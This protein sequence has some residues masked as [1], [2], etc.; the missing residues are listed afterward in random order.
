MPFIFPPGVGCPWRE[1][2][3]IKEG[4]LFM[5]HMRKGIALLLATLM[6]VPNIP[7]F[8]ENVQSETQTEDVEDVTETTEKEVQNVE[9][10]QLQEEIESADDASVF[11]NTGNYEVGIMEDDFAEDGSYTINI[12]EENPFFP[13]EVQFTC[14]GE[15]TDEWFMTPD[16]TVEIGGHTFKVS[17]YF[18]NT[19]VTQM[20][21]NVAGNTVAVYPEK[22]EFTNDGDGTMEMSLLP[23]TQRN[24]TVDLTGYTP[25]ELTMVSTDS[26]FTGANELKNTDKVV[27]TRLYYDDD[28]AISQSG[29][30]LDLSINTTSGSSGWEMIVGSGDQLDKNNVRYYVTVNL[31]DSENWLI[32]TIY[33]NNANGMREELTTSESSY[34]DYD[35]DRRNYS[36]KVV[37]TTH[38]NRCLA[39]KVN[40]QIYQNPKYNYL[41]AYEGKYS[42]IAEIAGATDITDKIFATD[43]TQNGAGYEVTDWHDVWITIV[44]YD[45]AGKESGILPVCINLYNFTS[46]G[47]MGAGALYTY[48]NGNYDFVYNTS[49][50]IIDS[51]GKR[52][53]TFEL[54]KGYSVSDVY[55]M[56]LNYYK[57]GKENN[58]AVTSA[59]AGKY[60]TIS[61]AQSAGAINIKDD[62]FRLNGKNGY[63][64]DYSLGVDFTIFVGNDGDS[65]QEIY[66]Y[67]VK[68]VEGKTTKPYNFSNSTF[69][70]FEKLVDKNGNYVSFISMHDS[71]D[72]E[73][74]YGEFNYLTLRVPA[75]TDLS[76]LAPCFT[77]DSGVTLYAANGS[78]KEV[79]GQSYHDFSK[80]PVQYTAVAEDGKA[81]KNYWLQVVS[82]TDAPNLYIN[83][84]ADPE[85]KTV[86][87]NNV[88]YSIR[89]ILLDGYH[90]YV[91][92]IVLANMSTQSIPN[93]K[94]EIN[95]EQVILDNYWT[96]SGNYDLSGYTFD[97]VT[98]VEDWSLAKIR[99]KAK[100][101]VEAGT[102]V[103]GTVTIKSGNTTLMV[104]TL[105]GL[106]GDPSITTKD[107]PAAIKYVPYGTVIQNNNKYSWNKTSYTMVSGTLPAGMTIR[108]NGEI[109][110]VPQETG[111]FTFTVRMNNSESSFKSDEAT[112]TLKVLDN[113]NENVEN[114]T[115]S[116]YEFRERLSNIVLGATGADSQKFVSVGE[117]DEFQA[118]YLDG[119]EL[120]KG[121]DYFA[122]RGSTRITIST[123]TLSR[124]GKGSHTIALEFRQK[125]TDTLKRAAQNYIVSD[126]NTNSGN[127]NSN[128]NSGNSGNQTSG[129]SGSSNSGSSSGGSSTSNVTG[130]NGTV[131]Q[132]E[133]DSQIA[134]QKTITYTVAAGDTLS[135]IALK[136]YGNRKFWRKI[137]A[138]NK[139]VLKNPN[140][141]YVGQKLTLYFDPDETQNQSDAD[142]TVKAN[143]YV[144]KPGDTLWKIATKLYKK[145]YYWK[146][147]YEANRKII[148]SP[149]KIRVG[150]MIE[151]P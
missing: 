16:D 89:E 94:V 132:T 44:A 18:D 51:T 122:E 137:Y 147:I 101:G 107:I 63:K 138:D 120:T 135:K 62:L 112:Y 145:G 23:L 14:D 50:S 67:N 105:T 102:N 10:T 95:S 80:G 64:A 8:A 78:S 136:M 12:P 31:T 143:T 54:Y 100:D 47:D 36:I 45:T 116:G 123:Q 9:E 48:Q 86:K 39:L 11:Y 19:V 124:G 90:R 114:A 25:V 66:H 55:Y 126:Q 40:D 22:K 73:D 141:I 61:E 37:D 41:K 93:L 149:E 115:D 121:S 4:V 96:L 131:S 133:K 84:L 110:G 75:G 87:Q 68:A 69:V 33:G 76:K 98:N 77:V 118:L 127:N 43:M 139:D 56:Y 113:T 15:V 53:L 79:S 57:M 151:L 7:A 111:E 74:S 49:R 17:A 146:N 130:T 70:E 117:L 52:Q 58:G 30:K 106:V 5:K 91:H 3:R 20:S 13:Y 24:L 72:K 60:A 83:S 92:D 97:G 128:G 108:E 65:D 142:S 6:I 104:L 125:D 35:K 85:A 2:H 81:S 150:Q 59:F 82:A 42:S 71:T 129:N 144:I 32:P 28:Y 21:L 109:Y 26:I 34:Y 27:W 103:S 99:L 140:R 38:S 148:K 134:T 88:T 29:D 1:L 46:G 119:Q